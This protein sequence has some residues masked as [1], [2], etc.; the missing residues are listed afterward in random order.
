MAI[1]QKRSTRKATGGRY[2]AIKGKA[3][4][5][6]G[7]VPTLTKLGELKQKFLRVLGGNTKARMLSAEKVSVFDPKTKKHTV[8]NIEQVSENPA[9][10]YFAGRN[11]L[12]KGTIVQTKSGRVKITSRPGQVATLTGVKVE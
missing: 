2:K 12:T 10:R 9:N 3:K 8:E 7:S 4:A 11:I 6:L 1:N 5:N